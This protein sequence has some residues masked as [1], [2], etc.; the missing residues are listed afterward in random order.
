MDVDHAL[1]TKC[2]GCG[3][4]ISSGEI[5]CCRL[6]RKSFHLTPCAVQPSMLKDLRLTR[7]FK[8]S[9]SCL[10]CIQAKSR[11]RGDNSNTPVGR[12]QAPTLPAPPTRLDCGSPQPAPVP[13]PEA[14]TSQVASI[15]DHS[16]TSSNPST[17]LIL[18]K[19]ERIEHQL[20][21]LDALSNDVKDVKSELN[22]V[23]D[24]MNFHSDQ[25][26]NLSRKVESF[27]N[28]LK[29]MS[30][31]KCEVSALKDEVKI[32][33]SDQEIKDQWARRSNIEL[34]GVPEKNSEMLMDIVDR[35]AK[36]SNF[37][38]QP[39]DIDFVTRVASKD[40]GNGRPK[41]IIIK[42]LARHRKDD[43]LTAL[44]KMKNLSTNHIGYPDQSR[45]IFANDHL[46]SA[47]KQLLN[48][49][50]IL[51]KDKNYKFVWVKNCMIKVRQN[52]KSPT[53]IIYNELDLKKIV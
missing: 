39:Y 22:G 2:G 19:L 48:R 12:I 10:N 21:R 18:Q 45:R 29:V 41:P 37:Q 27:D 44:R 20:C 50:K 15:A 32:I 28:Q 14:L 17:M 16:T 42:M 26:A 47:N 30:V 31:L 36:V 24:S 33:K 8:E 4:D 46:T 11:R 3:D 5:M 43:F 40:S 34:I 23:K 35:L 7:Q 38:L 53:Q 9:W 49:V 6:C 52:E 51:A 13:I 25:V 1:N